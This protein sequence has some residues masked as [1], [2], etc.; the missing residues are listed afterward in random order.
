MPGMAPA[1]KKLRKFS[2][3]S[4]I[5]RNCIARHPREACPRAGGERKYGC[6]KGLWIP[7]LRFAAAG[8]TIGMRYSRSS[9]GR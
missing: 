5:S 8:M 3:G 2:D 7:A 4:K 6:L 1:M 9:A